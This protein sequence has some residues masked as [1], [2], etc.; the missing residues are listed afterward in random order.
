MRGFNPPHLLELHTLHLSVYFADF[1]KSFLTKF[2]GNGFY[3]GM[4]K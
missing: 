4:E 1:N 3:Q 2:K